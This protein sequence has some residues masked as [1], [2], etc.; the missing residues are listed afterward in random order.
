MSSSTQ[1]VHQTKVFLSPIES[2]EENPEDEVVCENCGKNL[3]Q[4]T[5]LK[6][7]V[8][9][10]EC[11]AF[12]G[13]RYEEMKRKKNRNKVRKHRK[14][15]GLDQEL[16][17]KREK[18]RLKKEMIQAEKKKYSNQNRNI[19]NAD[20]ENVLHWKLAKEY[21]KTSIN[22]VKTKDKQ[23][24]LEIENSIEELYE[25]FRSEIKVLF[26]ENLEVFGNF[27]IDKMKAY[28]EMII[29]IPDPEVRGCNFTD[30]EARSKQIDNK[31]CKEWYEL[32]SKIDGKLNK[33]FEN[34]TDET[35]KCFCCLYDL[36]ANKIYGIWNGSPWLCEYEGKPGPPIDAEDIIRRLQKPSCSKQQ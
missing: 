36:S 4:S 5:I 30:H 25:K 8:Q 6:H 22:K 1:F 17:K 16:R 33:N 19:R 27:S 7:I 32:K 14:K 3:T 29:N 24:P 10:K 28:K 34:E 11:K 9:M 23:E 15:V 26:Q 31:I 13:P 35:K 12:Y 20:R 2:E 18:Y 21:Y